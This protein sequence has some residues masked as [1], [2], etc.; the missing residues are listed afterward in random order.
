MYSASIL[1]EFKNYLIDLG[2]Y[3]N[4]KKNAVNNLSI[5]EYSEEFKNFLD[6][7][8]DTTESIFTK[9]INEILEMDIVNGKL[10]LLDDENQQ[11]N[12]LYGKTPEN[13]NTANNE[14]EEENLNFGADE[15]SSINTLNQNNDFIEILNNIFED[16]T[17]IKSLDKNNDGTLDADEMNVFFENI[18]N[19]DGNESNISFEDILGGLEK[20]KE[21]K[22]ETQEEL[23]T[24]NEPQSISRKSPRGPYNG[25]STINQQEANLNNM[26]KE[27]LESELSVQNAALQEK[28]AVLEAIYSGSDSRLTELQQQIDLSYETYQQE[29]SLLDNDMANELDNAIS[30][31]N[32]KES[33]INNQQILIADQEITLVN[34]TTKVSN[35]QN[36][37]NSL[38]SSLSSLESADTSSMDDNDKADLKNKISNL[39]QEIQTT[40]NT[41]RQA[42]QEQQNAQDKLDELNETKNQLEEELASLNETKTS[43]EEKIAQ[44][45][46]EIK[47][48]QTAYEQA[49]TNY[50]NTKTQLISDTEN[51]IANIQIKI[52]EI[53]TAISQKTDKEK[54]TE[55]SL[56]GLSMYDEEKGK[57]LAASVLAYVDGNRSSTGMC[58]KGV[59]VAME[60]LGYTGLTPVKA[61]DFAATNLEGRSD[62]TEITDEVTVND[63]NSLPDGAIIC[64]SSYEAGHTRSNGK[65]GHACIVAHDENG[66]TIEVSD[67][68]RNGVNTNFYNWGGSYRVFIPC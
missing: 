55:Y 4:D 6:E 33:E 63:L 20:I 40:E 12:V 11:E 32:S 15:Y 66:N 18:K 48:L 22:K 29:L 10:T 13:K 49:K 41:L 39:K 23:E 52:N 54:S 37:L 59:R 67:Y 8:Y 26:T 14:S 24:K 43:I 51:E 19:I 56:G 16:E 5:F 34:Y 3:T 30:N 46:P 58:A 47:D 62:F 21:N 50:E 25:G 42:Q 31:I 64:W 65:A 57:A 35:T 1:N 27:Q 44:K 45:Y 28:Q 61:K 38:N 36:T 17:I 9:S 53:N 68:I 60:N 7:K 2:L